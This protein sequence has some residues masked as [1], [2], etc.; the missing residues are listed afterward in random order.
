[1][2]MKCGTK[3]EKKGCTFKPTVQPYVLQNTGVLQ[4]GSSSVGVFPLYRKIRVSA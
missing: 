4:A 3:H 1:M 2:N